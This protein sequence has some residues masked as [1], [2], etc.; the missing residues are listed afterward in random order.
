M[1]WQERLRRA[2]AALAFKRL[3]KKHEQEDLRRQEEKQ[4]AL[5]VFFRS[6]RDV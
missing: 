3:Q 1:P 2:N 6:S 5:D 4:R